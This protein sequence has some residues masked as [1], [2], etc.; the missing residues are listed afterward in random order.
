MSTYVKKLPEVEH[1]EE[2]RTMNESEMGGNLNL[3]Q[4]ALQNADFSKNRIL[5]P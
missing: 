5:K 1:F 2:G 3:I 4:N